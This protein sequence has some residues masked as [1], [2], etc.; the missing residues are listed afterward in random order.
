MKKTFLFSS[1]SA[2]HLLIPV[3]SS[4]LLMMS[5]ADASV[6][7]N[8]VLADPDSDPVLGDANLDGVRSG[9]DDEF[10]EIVNASTSS[11]DLSGWSINDESA[12]RYTFPSGTV[13]QPYDVFL[14][15][16]GGSPTF[17]GSSSVVND[18]LNLL[19]ESVLI[20]TAP[21]GLG[22]NNTGDTVSLLDDSSNVID[23]FTY[24]AEGGNDQSLTRSPDLTG[25]FALH[26]TASGSGGAIFSPGT[27]VDQS[28]FSAPVPIP[29][30][31]WLFTSGL[32]GMAGIARRK[33][34]L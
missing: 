6:L 5:N 7:I 24:G 28:F 8:E 18:A 29:P 3:L 26:S 22:L 27:M 15:F 10:V 33:K 14:L 1:G 17:D 21:A 2:H 32:L 30:A 11:V 20:D 31:A 9:I 25:A 16:G 4:I 12:L 23:S 13:L 19:P 34:K